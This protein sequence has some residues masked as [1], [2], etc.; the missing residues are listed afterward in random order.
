[1]EEVGYEDEFLD[2]LGFWQMF[3]ERG[4]TTAGETGFASHDRS[5]C[6]AWSAHP[7]YYL[8]RTVAGIKPQGVGF[9]EVLISPHLG[10]LQQV[11]V[12]MP[13]PRGRIRVDYEVK[14]KELLA[15]IT[16]PDGLSGA[17]RFQG[18][19]QQLVPGEQTIRQAL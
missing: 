2:Q 9:E 15:R 16:L 6:H 12:S 4:S 3:L 11:S 7:A 1:M 8:L 18:D 17:W 13:H 5:D 19:T 10:G 14:G